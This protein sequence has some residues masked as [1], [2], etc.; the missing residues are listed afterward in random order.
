MIRR[1]PLLLTAAL[2]LPFGLVGGRAHAAPLGQGCSAA[3]YSHNSVACMVVPAKG[4]FTITI[5][6]EKDKLKGSG[7]T[8]TAKTQLTVIRVPPPVSSKGGYGLR[9]RSTGK[10]KPLHLS[11]GSLWQYDAS[12]NSLV[13][14]GAV[15]AAGI[16]Q[17]VH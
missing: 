14:A 8:S 10:F 1:A 13:K 5:P 7:S 15:K 17:V 3:G 2:V 9:L 6:G 16:Y 12:K 11:S 4:K